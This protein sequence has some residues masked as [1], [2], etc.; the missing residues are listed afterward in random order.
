[1]NAIILTGHGRYSEGLYSA[2]C[3]VIGKQENIAFVNFPEGEGTSELDKKLSAALE[4]FKGAENI[5]ILA[6]LLGGT[7]FNRAVLLTRGM[8]NVRVLSGCNFQ[9]AYAAAFE[10][11]S[12]ID[13]VVKNIIDEAVESIMVFSEDA[14]D[15]GVEE[16]LEFEDIASFSDDEVKAVLR[17]SDSSVLSK[18]LKGAS[19]DVCDKIFRNLSGEHSALIKSAMKNM[20]PL[21]AEETE[22]AQ[23]E[24]VSIMTRL[25]EA[26]EEEGI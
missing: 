15:A 23:K 19:P 11:E 24:I 10:S 20:P 21:K 6:D 7:P 17:E 12:D 16:K 8:E 25:K 9:M 3:L 5:L 18:A 13:T 2:L 14:Y 26:D 22:A 1:M 4:S